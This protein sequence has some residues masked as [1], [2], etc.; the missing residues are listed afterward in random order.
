MCLFKLVFLFSSDKYPG[1][2]LL[3]HMV[4]RL[5]FIY[6]FCPCQVAYGI[7]VSQPGLNPGHG[8]ESAE[9]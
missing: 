8:S 1:I 4:F 9:S 5:F 7:L 3:E 6:F 2:D